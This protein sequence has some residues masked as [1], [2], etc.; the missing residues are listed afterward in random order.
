MKVLWRR[1]IV[2]WVILSAARSAP[3]MCWACISSSLKVVIIAASSRLPSTM[4]SAWALN[5]AKKLP[6]RGIR[7][8]NMRF[9][10]PLRFLYHAVARERR[11][12]AVRQAEPAAIDFRIV[13]AGRGPGAA[14]LARRPR[15][16]RHHAGHG[17]RAEIRV[18][19]PG[20]RL[21]GLDVRSL[22]HAS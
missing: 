17:N 2:S 9:S 15:E 6:S 8:P 5:S 16:P 12:L 7:R 1:V 10:L 18:R 14:R 3:S 20:D 21:A 4:R 22:R 11:A 19:H 13:R